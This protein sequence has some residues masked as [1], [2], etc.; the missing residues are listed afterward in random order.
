MEKEIVLPSEETLGQLQE[1]ILG[2]VLSNTHPEYNLRRNDRHLLIDSYPLFIVRVKTP[3]DIIETVL[4][5]K[6]NNWPIAIRSGGHS[7]RSLAA[8]HQC[9]LIDLSD[10]NQ[11][12][13]DIENQTARI[14]TGATFGEV[15]GALQPHDLAL[16]S[17][18]NATVGVGGI[19][20]G[21]GIGYM[22]RKYG[23]TSDRILSADLIMADGKKI[24]ISED[25]NQELFWGFRGGAGNFG[26]ATSVEFKLHQGGEIIGG[27]IFYEG[28]YAKDL[29]EVVHLA[30]K[31]PEEL[32]VMISLSLIFAIYS[33][34]LTRQKTAG[35]E[36]LLYRRFSRGRRNPSAF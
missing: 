28:A 3:E 30:N 26:I 24:H 31:A 8:G 34:K 16:T 6:E 25:E 10:M 32:T 21:S 13:I 15:A 29:Y 18:D 1:K 2:K 22:V 36:L 14:E 33:R 35:C 19:C 17:G 9:V 20:Q 7:T 27:S 23:L 5:A 4:L 12:E 11:I